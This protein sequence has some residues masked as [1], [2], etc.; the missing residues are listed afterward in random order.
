MKRI[1][2][3]T[4]ITSLWVDYIDVD[5][6]Q[7]EQ[8]V[9]EGYSSESIY[10]F[11]NGDQGAVEILSEDTDRVDTFTLDDVEAKDSPFSHEY[12]GEEV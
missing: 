4:V 11:I 10:D 9:K 2:K 1:T 3:R 7:Y 12:E 5:E 6:Q 8:W